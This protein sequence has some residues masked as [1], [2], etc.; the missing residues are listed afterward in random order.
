MLQ[1]YSESGTY[2]HLATDGQWAIYWD[3]SALDYVLRDLSDDSLLTSSDFSSTLILFPTSVELEPAWISTP[4]DFFGLVQYYSVANYQYCDSGDLKKFKLSAQGGNNYPFA[5]QITDPDNI[6]CASG[7]TC[8]LFVSDIQVTDANGVGSFDG[9]ISITASSSNLIQYKVSTT[10]DD[11]FNYGDGTASSTFSSLD[12]N[13][14]WVQVVDE[15]GCRVDSLVTVGNANEDNYGTIYR[16]GYKDINGNSARFNIK[17]RGYAGSITDVAYSGS[18]PVRY[19]QQEVESFN[20]FSCLRP[21]YM[22]VSLL[23]ENEGDWDEFLTASSRQYKGEWQKDT[24]SGYVTLWKGN[25]EPQNYSSSYDY[26]DEVKLTFIDGLASL[27]NKRYKQTNLGFNYFITDRKIIK[28]VAECLRE[29]KNAAKIRCAINLYET[30]HNTAATDDPLDQTY[31]DQEL[32]YDDDR[33]G[34]PLYEVLEYCLKTFAVKLF[35]WGGYWYIVRIEENIDDFDY[36]QYTIFGDYDAN[37]TIS[38]RVQVV[39]STN[40]SARAVMPNSSTSEEVLR[41]AKNIVINNTFD[42]RESILENYSFEYK[43]LTRPL[44]WNLV[45]VGGGITGGVIKQG[46][47]L[48]TYCY[49]FNNT[50]WTANIANSRIKSFQKSISY[51]NRDKFKFSMDVAVDK[52]ST[53][54][55]YMMIKA[56]IKVGSYYLQEDGTWT[57]TVRSCRFYPTPQNGWQTVEIESNFPEISA[58]SSSLVETTLQVQVYNYQAKNPDYG[59]YSES[60]GLYVLQSGETSFRAL[61]T[62]DLPINTKR[63]VYTDT[64]GFRFFKLIEGTDAESLYDILRPDDYATTTNERVWK[65]DSDTVPILTTASASPYSEIGKAPTNQFFFVD[66]I[67]ADVLNNGVEN[68]ETSSITVL[69]DEDNL[70][71]IEYDINVTDGG[72]AILGLSSA[73]YIYNSFYKLSDGSVAGVWSRDSTSEADELVSI[74]AK[75]LLRQYSTITRKLTTTLTTNNIGN[76][77]VDLTPLNSLRISQESSQIFYIN[78]IEIDDKNLNYN[79]TL[80]DS[81]ANSITGDGGNGG[82]FNSD[83]NNDFGSDFDIILV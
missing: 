44:F 26:I 24:G 30:N 28:I 45:D 16:V 51:R 78:S 25:F 68:T 53:A 79:V 74:L 43:N 20:V 48:G 29:T 76:T 63:T 75:T 18:V 54:F 77:H 70:E 40:A 1:D 62:S 42:K 23:E 5:E 9:E 38:P 15:L 83:F 39:G 6:S 47:E 67:V 17:K 46:K 49:R 13:S 56:L 72:D 69:V 65:S 8:D 36:R 50:N 33:K 41:P 27:K 2:S 11:N 10:F 81:K 35:Y 61:T 34:R 37:G 52:L 57:T 21:S 55:P 14:Y 66:N 73:E 60:G 64:G 59:A 12:P 58:G 7:S 4:P 19:V 3:T 22:E 80:Y 31:I 82:S 32:F 71:D